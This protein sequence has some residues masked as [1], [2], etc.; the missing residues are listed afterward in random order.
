MKPSVLIFSEEY[1]KITKGM[2]VVWRNHAS[3]ASKRFTV[4]IL[5]NNEHWAAEE[6]MHEFTSNANVNLHQLPFKM[7][8]TLVKALFGWC[9]QFW[10]LRAGRYALGQCLNLIMSP[11]III[12][13]T[14]RLRQIK[15]SAIFSHNGGWPAGVL[16]R[17]IIVAAFLARVPKRILIIHNYP[18][19]FK[20]IVLRTLFLPIRLIQARVVDFCATSIVTVSDSVKASLEGEIFYR[21]VVRIHNGIPSIEQLP[22]VL[23]DI[24]S[25]DWQPSGAVVG[26]VGALYPLKGPHVLLD[27]FKLVDIPCELAL[28]GPAEPFY[29]ETLQQKAELCANKVSF[30]G[31]HSDVDAFMQK[32]DILVVPSIAFESFGMVI[33]E[34]MKHK[35]PVICSDF[36]GMKEVVEHGVTGLVVPA[37]DDDAMANAI[38]KLLSDHDLML[39]MGEAGYRRLN[40]FFTLEKMVAQYDELLG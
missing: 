9:D 30:L 27:A 15:P 22:N 29:L 20:S 33:L 14:L 17:W 25:L 8:S 4:D 31:F 21:S 24:P 32:I 18:N 38:T 37:S 39:Q 23:L 11:L 6:V 5:L 35:K 36:G 13:L 12:Y 3:E 10:I 28:L 19:S 26:F 34:A 7:P 1:T 40:V 16:C 2:F